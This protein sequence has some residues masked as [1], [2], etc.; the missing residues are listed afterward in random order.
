MPASVKCVFPDP[1]CLTPRQKEVLELLAYG[2][3]TKG[4]AWLLGISPKT[5]EYH[6]AIIYAK[7]NI[8]CPI[9]LAHFSIS[10]GL[11][12]VNHKLQDPATL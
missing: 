4:A 3:N 5:I 2:A 1:A 9:L 12:P 11:I 6:R 10:R 8:H 7:L